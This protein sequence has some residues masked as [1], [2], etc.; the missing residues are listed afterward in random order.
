MFTLTQFPLPYATDALAPYISQET[1]E[2]HHGKHVATYIDNLNKLIQ[3]TP[4][5]SV[6]LQEIIL[7]S[8]TKPEDKKI[9][10]NAAQIY[11]HNFFFS[12][13]CP[14]CDTQIPQEIVDAFGG[15]QKFKDEFKSAATSLFGSG[16]TWLVRDGDE[17]KIINT[18]NADH[19]DAYSEGVQ[20]VEGAT[21][22]GENISY[23]VYDET[24]L[25]YALN[26][27]AVSTIYLNPRE[28]A[29][30]ADIY[31]GTAARKSLTIIGS[32]GTKFGHTAT[33]GGQLQL[34]L[35]DRFTIS[36][37]EIIQRSG[38]KTWGHIVFGASGNENGVYTIK[39]CTFNSNGNQGIY[40]NENTSGAVYNIE[41]CTFNGNFGSAD[42]AVTIENKRGA[43]F[44]VNVTGCTF[45]TDS[46]KVCYLYDDNALRLITDPT[47][48][49]VCLNR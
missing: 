44:T 12:G 47:V 40:I 48:T 20:A 10:N 4:Y 35:F 42:G 31:N 32:E 5:E 36:N 29:Y 26:N 21:L 24:S 13:M 14:N 49:P 33:T 7:E 18:S 30:I 43:E 37:C 11:N 46:K 2:T 41:N 22:T 1:L 28:E 8:A 19:T 9:F 15:E 17:L 45:N 6:S 34:A 39:N 16:Y 38:Y 25:Q 23:V 27:A 3:N